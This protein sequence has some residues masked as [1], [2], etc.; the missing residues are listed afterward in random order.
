MLCFE[1]WIYFPFWH[2]YTFNFAVLGLLTVPLPTSFIQIDN[3]SFFNFSIKSFPQK[4]QNYVV[5]LR[6]TIVLYDGTIELNF[7]ILTS[8]FIR[9]END[10]KYV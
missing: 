9:N 5:K 6:Y 10:Y 1:L 8:Y 2:F 3:F 7:S 4:S